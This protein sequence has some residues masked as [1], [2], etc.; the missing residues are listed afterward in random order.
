MRAAMRATRSGRSVAPGAATWRN[1][2]GSVP[3]ARCTLDS[4]QSLAS[5]FPKQAS[6]VFKEHGAIEYRECAADDIKMSFGTPFAKLAKL[7]PSDTVVF[8]W[9]VYKSKADRDK[10]NKQIMKD[11][12]LAAMMD[13]KSMPFDMKR[14]TMGGFKCMVD[15]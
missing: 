4:V 14:M 2:D 15:A 7:K 6:V 3:S 9:V 13:P 10:A 1:T 11:P 5:Y 8:S 12:R